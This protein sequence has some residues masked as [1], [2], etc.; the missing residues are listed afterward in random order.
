MTDVV[1]KPD[2]VGSQSSKKGQREQYPKIDKHQV[3]GFSVGFY[4]LS[5]YS[6]FQLAGRLLVALRIISLSISLM[7]KRSAL[8]DE[9]AQRYLASYLKRIQ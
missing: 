9:Y 5:P 6:D 7:K 1:T 8:T 2:N 3:K 4:I